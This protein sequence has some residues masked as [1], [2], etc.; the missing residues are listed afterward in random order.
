M[1]ICRYICM[2]LCMYKA[3]DICLMQ[4]RIATEIRARDDLGV[5]L[6]IY[7]DVP[8]RSGMWMCVEYVCRV[9]V[10]ND[11]YDLP[12]SGWWGEQSAAK[13]Q[14]KHTSTRTSLDAAAA[15]HRPSELKGALCA[16]AVSVVVQLVAACATARA[17]V[18]GRRER[19]GSVRKPGDPPLCIHMIYLAVE[20]KAGDPHRRR[21]SNMPPT[22]DRR[23]RRRLAD[24]APLDGAT[25]RAAL[26]A[27]RK[28]V[29]RYA[30]STS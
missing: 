24:N 8:S 7:Y 10:C 2:F 20:A 26:R 17:R 29:C 13:K 5:R 21:R 1:Y 23:R 25:Q 30:T 9:G 28:A 27:V 18:R 22:R 16:V 6:C 15:E 12:M 14:H 3:R 4:F 19:R 11:V